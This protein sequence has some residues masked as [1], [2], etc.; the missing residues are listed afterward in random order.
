MTCRREVTN[1]ELHSAG[2]TICLNQSGMKAVF[3]MVHD[4]ITVVGVKKFLLIGRRFRMIAEMITNPS[5]GIRINK[6]GRAA[7]VCDFF[8]T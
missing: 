6:Y 7:A 4:F 8:N 5:N 3:Q 1:D 2:G